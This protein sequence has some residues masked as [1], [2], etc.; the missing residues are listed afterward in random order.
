MAATLS[1][2]AMKAILKGTI[3]GGRLPFDLITLTFNADRLVVSY[4]H[5]GREMF[6]QECA[7]PLVNG[8][9]ISLYDHVGT[10][11]ITLTSA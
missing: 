1:A 2:K 8:D 11:G 4:H 3:K 7:K 5:K 9:T 10:V 6:Q